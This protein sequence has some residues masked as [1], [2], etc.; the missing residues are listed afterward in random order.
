MKL[1]QAMRGIGVTATALI[2]ALTA[3]SFAD[4]QKVRIGYDVVPIHL[5]PL[6]F[7]LD[8]DVLPNK[9][10]NY[11][12]DLIRFRGSSLQLQALAA[13]ELDI[14]VLAFSTLAAGIV[15]ARQDIVAIADVAQDGPGFSSVYAVLEDSEIQTVE[16]LDGKILSIN[17]AGGAVDMAARVVLTKAG[18]AP[19]SDVTILEAGFGGQEAMLREGKTDVAVFIAPFWSRAQKTGGVRPLFHQ[20]DGLGDTQFL[21]YAAKKEFIEN[22]RDVLVNVMEDYIRGIRWLTDEANRDEALDMIAAWNKNERSNYEAWALI[23]SEDY[24]HDA[25]GKVNVEA[26]QSNINTLNELGLLR[27]TLDVNDIVDHSLVEE[28][29]ARIK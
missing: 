26:L 1:L 6:A 10:K 18:L 8:S 28:A 22:N 4:V 3:P 29:A 14:A 17:R 16:D 19:G 21:L 7:G 20:R 13:D 23:P 11:E 9:G 5:A 12:P 2:F 27:E 15:N 25:N 24:R